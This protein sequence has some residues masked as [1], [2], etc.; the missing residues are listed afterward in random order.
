M[1]C[2]ERALQ[3]FGKGAALDEITHGA[4]F[5]FIL[6]QLRQQFSGDILVSQPADLGKEL[7]G[8]NADVRLLQSG[9][10]KNINDAFFSHDGLGHELAYC[11]IK[12]LPVDAAYRRSSRAAP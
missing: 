7:F 11:G 1:I 3:H 9:S 2:V 5:N 10:G 6:E 4:Q 8:K 12:S